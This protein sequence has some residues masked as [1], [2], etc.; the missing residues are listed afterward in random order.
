MM[1]PHDPLKQVVV[2]PSIHIDQKL[3][4][5]E[6]EA[7]L[8]ERGCELRVHP[9]RD[10]EL[11]ELVHAPFPRCDRRPAGDPPVK[12]LHEQ[13]ERIPQGLEHD[14]HVLRDLCEHVPRQRPLQ[15]VV[16]IVIAA[17]R[18]HKPVCGLS[19]SSLAVV[20][21][22]EIPRLVLQRVKLAEHTAER[23][24]ATA[25][26]THVLHRQPHYGQRLGAWGKTRAHN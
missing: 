21:E 5:L 1:T 24:V 6:A 3:P 9:Q 25:I 4:A 26:E 13:V 20:A 23:A 11:V 17:R 2:I 16:A 19:E 15:R 18:G 10:P 8:S 14:E 22:G 7:Q 12:P